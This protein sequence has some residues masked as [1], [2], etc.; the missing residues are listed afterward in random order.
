VLGSVTF[1]KTSTVPVK[2]Q[3]PTIPEISLQGSEAANGMVMPTHRH[4]VAGTI[5]IT[6]QSVQRI[7]TSPP[8]DIASPLSDTSVSLSG[9]KF[10]DSSLSPNS[11]GDA[12][13]EARSPEKSPQNLVSPKFTS[14]YPPCTSHPPKA[15]Q[16]PGILSGGGIGK[17]PSPSQTRKKQQKQQKYR[18]LRYHEYVPPS[19]PNAKPGKTTPKPSSKPDTPYSLLL[20]QQQLFLQLQVLQQQYPN[21]VLMQKLPDL[22]NT[23]STK[24]GKNKGR[25]S[26]T[27]P[28]NLEGTKQVA[29]VVPTVPQV[30]QVEQ[31]NRF[32]STTVRFDEL[33]VSDLKAAC[34]EMGMIVS[35]KKAELVERLL[36]HN[37]GVLP[38]T[39]LPDNQSK[40]IR[41]HAFSSGNASSV[42]SQVSTFSPASPS[43]SPI[44]QFPS[45]QYSSQY[46]HQY[47][48]QQQ[49]TL[50]STNTTKAP[51]PPPPPPPPMK[52][53]SLPN[54]SP[55]TA[56]QAQ[57][58]PA[59]NFQAQFNELYEK[60]KRDY[61]SQR[62]PMSLAP[63][64]EL[65]DMVAIKF[66]RPMDQ[67]QRINRGNTLPNHG[68]G[69]P[70][71]LQME[72]QSQSLPSSPRPL[73][74]SDN[75]LEI[76]DDTPALKNP[77]NAENS[78]SSMSSVPPLPGPS[79]SEALYLTPNSV[80]LSVA[81]TSATVAN[82]TASMPPPTT[83]YNSV[84]RP[85][86]SSVPIQPKGH[87]LNPPSYG[88]PLMQRSI[89]LSGPPPMRHTMGPVHPMHR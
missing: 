85:A 61:I 81:A 53:D 10:S 3:R 62:A 59:S 17:A 87:P 66:S 88:S 50:W 70:N 47:Q 39:A 26:V 19:R 30:L 84:M 75:L 64:P 74:P 57:V 58:F 86:R 76:M 51:L 14:S 21:G 60:Q 16:T 18:K 80:P 5:P 6:S 11:P 69:K 9:R 24:K 36:E 89:S 42:E 22:L 54:S 2:S 65:N 63:R 8:K 27:S 71:F 7:D 31:P 34:K 78:F 72:K 1:E 25:S 41:R 35:G 68:E 38:V 48:Q 37:N 83:A 67:Q 23:M 33:K 4:S 43:L 82:S 28:P 32:N 49:S 44:F 79:T 45:D 13:D 46:Q 52:R 15:T 77:P 55:L 20:Q 40:D 73:S 29:A 56:P 12:Y